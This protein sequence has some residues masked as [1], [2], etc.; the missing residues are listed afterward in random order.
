MQAENTIVTAE[1]DEDQAIH[2]VNQSTLFSFRQKEMAIMLS[3]SEATSVPQTNVRVADDP[4][5]KRNIDFIYLAA[6]F[7]NDFQ[8]LSKLLSLITT[9][10]RDQFRLKHQELIMPYQAPHL[11]LS[12]KSV[13]EI[14]QADIFIRKVQLRSTGYAFGLSFGL[15]TAQMTW[16]I[17][18]PLFW[19]HHLQHALQKALSWV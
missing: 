19:V 14:K 16:S 9:A 3:V 4:L 12:E 7:K 15:R 2:V 1:I 5:T 13:T 8:S 6:R 11:Q 10:E 18:L 17:D